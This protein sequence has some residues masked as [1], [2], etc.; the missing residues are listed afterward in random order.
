MMEILDYSYLI[1]F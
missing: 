1:I